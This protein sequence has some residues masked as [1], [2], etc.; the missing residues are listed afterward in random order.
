MNYILKVG[1]VQ[2]QDKIYVDVWGKSSEIGEKN[3]GYN[4]LDENPRTVT[5][6]I[7]KQ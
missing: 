3:P 7:R 4:I 2:W 1:S 5:V 6:G